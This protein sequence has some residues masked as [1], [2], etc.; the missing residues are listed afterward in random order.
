MRFLQV[1]LFVSLFIQ[2]LYSLN[3]LVT[4]PFPSRSHFLSFSRLFQSLAHKGHNLTVISYY[5]QK[6][7]LPKYRD[8][9]I[10][11]V[12]VIMNAVSSSI[13]FKK[14]KRNRLSSYHSVSEG[15]KLGNLA[16][17]AIFK[18]MRVQKF[19]QEENNFD[20]IIMED[21]YSECLWTI[22]QR[23]RS[24]VVRLVSHTLFPWNGRSLANPLASSYVPN[25]F[26][27]QE[28]KMSFLDRLENTIMNLYLILFFNMSVV[29]RQ[30]EIAK[31]YVEIDEHTFDNKYY[32]TSVVLMNTHYVL[33]NPRPMV[34]N[35]IEVG[36]IH[37]GEVQKLSLVSIFLIPL[38]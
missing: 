24:P 14:L 7:A 30:I 16:C 8:I 6:N 31:Q 1:V 11:S 27:L 29:P 35:M 37:I 10:G 28:Y 32:N 21:F 4:I 13:D 17:N 33:Q 34:P 20:S 9:N 22:V 25:I 23:Y 38:K 5:P 18:S 26:K 19:L 2:S 15:S 36:G 12:D 3:I